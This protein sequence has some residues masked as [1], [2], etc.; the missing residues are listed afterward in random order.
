MRL[1][2]ISA[3]KPNSTGSGVYLT[4][5]AAAFARQGSVCAVLAG[6]APGDAP[7]FAPG[8]DFYP[9]PFETET[10]PFPVV[11]MSDDMP[12]P[13]TRY[14][15][16]TSEMK[17]LFEKAF[18]AAA[19]RAVAEFQPDVL[20]CHHLYFLTAI[21]RRHF[22]GLKVVA[23]CHGT[24]LRQFQKTDLQRS[25]IRESIC[26]L[27]G[28]FALHGPQREEILRLFGTEERRVAVIGTGYNAQIFHRGQPL[29][30]EGLR[31]IYAGKLCEKK[32]LLALLP[33]LTLLWQRGLRFSLALAGGEG[34]RAEY[35]RI[36]SAA[37]AVPFSVE[38]LGKLAQP[39]LAEA[40][41]NA[42]LFVLPSYFEGLPLVLVEA[43][44]CGLPVVTTD[45]PGI[46]PWLTENIP[47]HRAVFVPPPAM[48]QVDAPCPGALPEFIRR[49]A[50]GIEEAVNA[51]PAFAPPDTAG[52]SWDAV[53][54]RMEE[55]LADF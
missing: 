33:A 25:R 43:M 21:V 15:D 6:T 16:L 1:L 36:R 37:E 34:N 35:H 22:P 50:D 26:D 40:F 20:V 2:H 30:H 41:R 47:G 19:E 42:D 29:A 49:L 51:L 18:L 24:D 7:E 13:A 10:L 28:I 48:E 4:E 5:L 32:G 12:Y 14:R 23:V 9:V 27:D 17:T 46:R 45:L 11:G 52:V 55:R 44:A 31:L 8:I 53:A 54:R 38:L 3:Q 39:Q